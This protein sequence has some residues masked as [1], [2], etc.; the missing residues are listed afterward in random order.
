MAGTFKFELVSP[1]RILMS[2]DADEAMLPGADGDMTVLA[3]HAPVVT[4]LRPGVLAVKAQGTTKRI[5]VKGGFADVQ[6]QMVT[7]LAPSA[8]DVAELTG[9]RLTSEIEA[10]ETSFRDAKDDELKRTAYDA[11]EALKALQGGKAA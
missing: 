7:V 5:Y 4:N 11:I 6:A 2:V 3:G 1:E 9:A 8:A 10:A